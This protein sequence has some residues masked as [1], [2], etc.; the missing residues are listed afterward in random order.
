VIDANSI[1]V[2]AFILLLIRVHLRMSLVFP[3]PHVIARGPSRVI[4]A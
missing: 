3:Q 1:E 4:Y 2:F